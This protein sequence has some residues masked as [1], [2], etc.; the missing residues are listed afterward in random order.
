[1][2]G[3][4][5]NAAKSV[6][7][8]AKWATGGAGL[9]INIKSSFDSMATNGAFA[10]AL[11]Q[12][13]AEQSVLKERVVEPSSDTVNASTVNAAAAR[14]VGNDKVPG[15]TGN[16]FG[17]TEIAITSYIDFLNET[18]AAFDTLSQN[19]LSYLAQQTQIAQ[20]QW[21]AVNQEYQTIRADF[22]ARNSDLYNVATAAVKSLDSTNPDYSKLTNLYN[23]IPKLISMI[24]SQ[25][26]AIKKIIA[27]LSNKISTVQN[28]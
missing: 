22:N 9:P 20:S 1:L 25:V 13:S 6:E 8:T 28:T 3:L 15:V 18:N 16:T 14:I 7:D 24:N 12:G 11:A 26:E 2:S 10:V 17:Q 27:D 19:S 4:A 5:T 23:G 21:N